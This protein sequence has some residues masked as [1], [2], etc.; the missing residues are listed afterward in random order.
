MVC[1]YH[2]YSTGTDLDREQL[3]SELKELTHSITQL[4]HY[5]LDQNSL[6]VNGK[7]GHL[8]FVVA[9]PILSPSKN[10]LYSLSMYQSLCSF[11]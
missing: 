8:N 11:L 4:G 6:Y 3:Y 5:I 2:Q 9:K 1:A 10:I 7:C